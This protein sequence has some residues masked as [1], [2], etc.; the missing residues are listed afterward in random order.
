MPLLRGFHIMWFVMVLMIGRSY[1]IG[2]SFR[3]IPRGLYDVMFDIF[4]MP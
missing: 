1:G 3:M 2:L 4:E